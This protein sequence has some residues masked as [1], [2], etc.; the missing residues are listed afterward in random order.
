M[1]FFPLHFRKVRR[2]A[3][4]LL[5]GC[6]FAFLN[7]ASAQ[8]NSAPANRWLFIVDIS[9]GMQRR[10]E[11]ARQ[12]AASLV[13]SGMHG[14]MRPGD[15]I[16]LWTFND[17]LHSGQFPLQEW[18]PG[19]SRAI[20]QRVFDFLKSQKNEKDSRLEKIMPEMNQVIAA[21]E[22][23]TV[24]LISEGSTEIHGT[25]FD[26]KINSSYQ[27]WRDQQEK[28][29][30][31]FVTL[32]R[33][34][35]GKIA[36]YVVNTPPFPLELPALPEEL[37]KPRVTKPAVAEVEKP[38]P[39]QPKAIPPLILSGKKK[40]PTVE[41]S[42]PVVVQPPTVKS[43][44]TNA[45]EIVAQNPTPPP[46]SEPE[47]IQPQPDLTSPNRPEENIA[48][49]S[50]KEVVSTDEIKETS[51]SETPAI[52]SP[53]SVQTVVSAAPEPRRKGFWLVVSIIL[54]VLIIVTFVLLRRARHKS[55]ASLITR[56]LDRDPR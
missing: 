30:M 37:L 9:R 2:F 36:Q 55:D 31:P 26:A 48:A 32:L 50:K 18:K 16:G 27:A 43:E 5:A 1:T 17:A 54:G 56:S 21:S 42:A 41:T 29:A 52:E 35:D 38:E 3:L 10:A 22:F 33:A 51:A 47:K 7:A 28:S 25:P 12:I 23:I 20:A 39:A 53:A 34:R 19:D 45:P 6:A 24:I 40:E 46:I 44:I 4:L 8:T 14:Q 15:S 13:D 49:P 11:A